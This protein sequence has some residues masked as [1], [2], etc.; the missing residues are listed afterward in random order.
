MTARVLLVEND[1]R[2]YR[3]AFRDVALSELPPGDVLVRVRY[4]SLNYKDAL[5]VTGAGKVVRRFPMVPGIDLVGEVVDAAAGFAGGQMVLCT[6]QGLGETRWGGYATHCRLPADHLIALPEGFDAFQAMAIGTAGFTAMRCVMALERH[7]VAPGGRPLIVTGAGGGVGSLAV[8]IATRLG[9]AVTA[10]SGRR[11]IEPWLRELGAS[12]FVERQGLAASGPALASE[13]WCGGVDAV[14]GAILANLLAQVAHGGAIA[15][16]GMAAAPELPTTVFPFILREVA[17]LG[18][19]SGATP[20]AQR[21]ETWR[22]LARDLPRERLAAVAS[23]AGLSRVADLAR[24]VLAGR[25]RGR[26]VIDVA[27]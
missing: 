21:A 2:G 15:C 9:F 5:A 24:D 20:P 7:G 6:G 23:V 12:A 25:V 1:D 11:E 27:A 26:Y 3:A 17:L 4:S 8:L 10:V 22:R 13:R 14:G 18:I 16:C 19:A